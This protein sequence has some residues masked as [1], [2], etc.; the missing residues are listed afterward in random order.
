MEVRRD[1]NF[2]WPAKMRTPPQ[3]CSSKKYCEYHNNDGHLIE[4]CITLRREIENFIQ[5]G[6]LIK[7]LAGERERDN[8]SC[9]SQP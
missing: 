2:S 8:N 7:F 4:D 5:N 9:G 1:P 6:K 3:R